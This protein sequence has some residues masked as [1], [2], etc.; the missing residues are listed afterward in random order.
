MQ[1]V[2]GRHAGASP[3]SRPDQYQPDSGRS[4]VKVQ[5]EVSRAAGQLPR[6]GRLLRRRPDVLLGLQD[7]L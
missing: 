5:C 3:A 7:R 1:P 6:R 4:W 2:T